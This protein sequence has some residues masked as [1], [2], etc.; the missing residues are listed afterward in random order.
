[1]SVQPPHSIQKNPKVRFTE[2]RPL[3]F[4]FAKQ[5]FSK[6]EQCSD[7]QIRNKTPPITSTKN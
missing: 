1:M 7:R 5:F 6:T 3:G 2:K 4:F